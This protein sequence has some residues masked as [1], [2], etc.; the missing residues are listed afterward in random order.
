MRLLRAICRTLFALTFI[1]SGIL[2]LMDP[3]G[4]GLV[5]GEYLRIMHLGALS[6]ASIHMG[7]VLSTLEFLVGVSVLVGLE[8]RIFSGIALC[9]TGIFSLLTLYLALFNP[10]SDCGCFGE[11]IHLSNW[12]TFQKD[13]VLLVLATIIFTGR[14]KATK[15]ASPTV[16]WIFVGVFAALALS[17]A[18]QSLLGIPQV[19]FTAYNVGTSLVGDDCSATPQL[20]T[21]FIYEK[22]GRQQEFNLEN[23]PDSTWTFVDSRTLENGKLEGAPDFHLECQSGPCFVVTVYDRERLDSTQISLV[24]ALETQASLAA[25]PFEVICDADPKTLVTLNR[26][27]G[28]ITYFNDGIIVGKWGA[29]HLDGFD[30][31]L[32]LEQDPDVMILEHR[33]HQ[34]LYI[35]IIILSILTMLLVI[36]YVC[37][38]TYKSPSGEKTS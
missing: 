2:K 17:I 25:I 3:V 23:L 11:A 13:L 28:G 18:G 35:S 29:N 21:S 20:E 10:I 31:S 38:M 9:L 14:F 8:M 37:R 24:E 27:N 7:V 16:Q 26:S 6:G 32:V 4:T 34:Q 19:D 15:I 22:D 5:V 33:I 1:L 12:Q 36:R 30:L